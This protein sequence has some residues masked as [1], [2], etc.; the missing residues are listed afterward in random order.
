MEQKGFYN[1]D[2][3]GEFTSVVDVQL[4]AA[5]IHP[6]GGRNDIPQRL[7]RQFSIFNCTL[8]SNSSIDKIFQTV[9]QGYFCM[10]RGF[11]AEVCALASAIVPTT[12]R[13]W[14]A[15]KVKVKLS[16][17]ALCVL[18]LKLQ[19]QNEETANR[20]FGVVLTKITVTDAANAC[21]VSLHL[22][23]AGP[24]P[25]LAGYPHSDSRSVQNPRGPY[26]PLLP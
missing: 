3:P 21:K 14:Q 4:T 11:P 19:L 26:G 17:V 23:P 7:K 10:E 8:P 20:M 25:N 9:A 15:I 1:L 6:G 2:R 18:K 12:R 5:M 13:L 22:Q 24:E 16:C